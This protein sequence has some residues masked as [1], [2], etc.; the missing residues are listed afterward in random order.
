MCSAGIHSAFSSNWKPGLVRSKLNQM[1]SDS[2]NTTDEV[3]SAII[4]ALLAT[5]ASSP[6][7]KTIR[8]APRS[9]RNVVRERI[10]KPVISPSN[11]QIEIPGDQRDHADHHGEGIVVDISAL[12]LAGARGQIH[13]H[14]RDAGGTEPVDDRSIAAL[15]Q[16]AAERLR[17]AHEDRVIEL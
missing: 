16:D 13:G 4:R 9:G 2:R 12:Q 3:M 11:E 14:L 1:K 8:T 6:R 10:G 5:N 15:P 7:V 17:R